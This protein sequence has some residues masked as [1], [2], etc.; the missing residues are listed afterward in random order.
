MA[1]FCR[2][3]ARARTARGGALQGLDVQPAD[4]KTSKSFEVL[5]SRLRLWHPRMSRWTPRNRDFTDLVCRGALGVH[6][7]GLAL[8]RFQS[9]LVLLQL[10]KLFVSANLC[11]APT[12]RPSILSQLPKPLR[13]WVSDRCGL[14]PRPR[15]PPPSPS[16]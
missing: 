6:L 4:R 1:Q 13:F 8:H 5:L 9:L 16:I 12:P 15:P 3:A 2:A 11:Q 10:A 7:Y 14:C